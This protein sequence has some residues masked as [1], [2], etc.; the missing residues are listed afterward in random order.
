MYRKVSIGKDAHVECTPISGQCERE[1][2]G[3]MAHVD[4]GADEPF[5]SEIGTFLPMALCGRNSLY[6]LRKL[7][8]DLDNLPS[9]LRRM[10]MSAEQTTLSPAVNGSEVIR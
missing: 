8:V 4:G 7:V 6:M 9:G 1:S 10:I 2:S 3:V 5:M